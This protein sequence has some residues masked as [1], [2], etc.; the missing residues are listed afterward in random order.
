M[1][2]LES[3]IVEVFGKKFE[4]PE[5]TLQDVPQELWR[6]EFYGWAD[7]V[8]QLFNWLWGEI[9]DALSFLETNI[10]SRLW[11]VRDYIWGGIQAIPSAVANALNSLLNVIRNNVGSIL[12]VVNSISSSIGSVF[13]QVTGAIS[14][15]G[16]TLSSFGSTLGNIWNSIAGLGSS[17]INSISGVINNI[18]SYITSAISSIATTLSQLISAMN[19]GFSGIV[20]NISSIVGGISGAISSV[21]SALSSGF[22]QISSVVST[23][24][25]AIGDVSSVIAGGFSSVYG[26]LSSFASGISDSV[27][28]LRDWLL[29][30]FNTLGALMGQVYTA[31][32]GIIIDFPNWFNDIYSWV[33][34]GIAQIQTWFSGAWNGV[35]SF[36]TQQYNNL[37]G[38]VNDVIRSLQGFINPLI[39]LKFGF[40]KFLKSIQDFFKDPLGALKDVF[41]KLWT[42]VQP[43]ISY[44]VEK[45][46]ST[47]E[48]IWS[49]IK[50]VG[51]WIWERVV[52]IGEWLWGGLKLLGGKIVST[53]LN[54]VKWLTTTGASI[55]ESSKNAVMKVFM[56]VVEATGSMVSGFFTE[57]ADRI[58]KG[59]GKGEFVEFGA[60][61]G[62][63]ASTQFTFRWM[64]Q[65]LM[66]LGEMTSKVRLAPNVHLRILSAG[67]NKEIAFE[68]TLG[69][70]LKH[71]A[72]EIG[73]YP[74]TM[75][76]SMIYGL[77]IWLSRPF[78]KL[79]SSMAR[80]VFPIELPDI[81]TL[82]EATRRSMPT[83]Q[84]VT[85][86]SD[87]SRTMA[88]FGYSSQV[89]NW[90]LSS[91]EG[92]WGVQITDRFDKPKILPRALVYQL[93]TPSDFCRMMVRDIF[94]TPENPF[95]SFSKAIQ[96]VGM[97]EDVAKMYYMLHFRYPDMD[98]LYEF[99]CRTAVGLAWVTEAPN[100]EAGLGASGAKAPF[101]LNANVKSSAEL[102]T[103]LNKQVTDWLRLYGKW[104]DYAPFAWVKGFTAD[105]L[106]K[107]DMMAD[108]PQRRDAR[109]MYKW[110]IISDA[111]VFK[112]TTSR[113]MHPKWVDN[114]VV[115]ECMNALQEERTYGRTGVLNSLERGLAT[116]ELTDKLLT[117]LTTVT[118]LGK[119]YP[120]RF[121]DGE[122]KLLIF[123]SMYDRALM[124]LNRLWSHLQMGFQRNMIPLANCI[125]T[126]L[127]ET[128]RIKTLLGI[129][130]E[131]DPNY[132]TVWMETFLVRHDIETTQRI[133]Y[134]MRIFIYRA[135]QLAESGEQFQNLVEE[136]ADKARLT[137]VETEL[138]ISLGTAFIQ[139]F[140]R[141]K[142]L[143]IVKNMVKGKLRSGSWN[144]E[145]C[146]EK[147]VSAGM[148]KDDAEAYL[149]SDVKT[150]TVSTD[151]L[152]TMAERIPISPETLKAKMDAEGVPLDEQKMYVPYA[153]ASEIAE[154]QG[155]VV[156][157]IL[158]DYVEGIFND[159]ELIQKLDDVATLDG[160]VQSKLGVAWV[161]YSPDERA[162]LINL[163]KKRRARRVTPAQKFKTI[164]SDKL[165]SLMENI[166]IDI[167][168]LKDKM[169]A[170]NLPLEEQKLYI[171][172]AW[173]SEISEEIG[174]LATELITDF[175]KGM[176]TETGLRRELNN[177]AT[178]GGVVKRVLGIDWI[179]LSPQERELLVALAK[180]R[181]ARSG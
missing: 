37:V 157:E 36:F 66:W 32:S 115:G 47:A 42:W 52:D 68:M 59:K 53:V 95:P 97:T 48:F 106:I 112:V 150:R 39:D 162:I 114:I 14:N 67:V 73:N 180:L 72:K 71:M 12:N 16:V 119:E 1:S 74:D 70:I 99:A 169:D 173:A 75:G 29:S 11:S 111:D 138:M 178:L 102:T 7:P 170:E 13:S 5:F 134:W 109:W 45:L 62:L 64:K 124:V 84:F 108:I 143:T 145:Q 176:F 171:Q 86:K 22:Q 21:S 155:K 120:V 166:P 128:N 33:T 165:I 175:S 96:M 81:K 144:V 17:I 26:Y 118:I 54:S 174:R 104:H 149:E 103:Y 40:D 105:R 135:T 160:T 98:Q 137:P 168:T 43:T 141:S 121:L 158:S 10:L 92:E 167:K 172:N 91:P 15:L 51:T 131:A 27:I 122:K 136:Y 116:T 82:S 31:V 154:E 58:A 89:V 20:S 69:R 2:Y 50:S 139:A 127:G 130:L 79:I 107:M 85:F 30:G 55:I 49:G 56:P 65:A 6:V 164:S 132:L 153:V 63:I 133:R 38:G 151:K 8:G 179:V 147:L 113:G 44:V 24:G 41:E 177:V 28:G 110:S 60:V 57:L 23:I 159:A 80:D 148:S 9:Q 125:Q 181:K 156:T 129:E 161:N 87:M 94:G 101:D 34:G 146:V 18:Q 77:S 3:A 117:K 35:Q 4:L 163:A 76:Q 100:M 19:S 83:K 123:R 152:I 46:K 25:S 140:N 93:P 142:S 78:S 90:H 126:M 61:I 88:L